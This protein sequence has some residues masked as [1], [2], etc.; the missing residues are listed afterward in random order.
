[1]VV[2][3]LL[4]RSEW[5]S[6]SNALPSQSEG[7]HRAEDTHGEVDGEKEARGDRV[8]TGRVMGILERSDRLYVATFDV[9]LCYSSWWWW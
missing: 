8:P 7:S 5:K 3:S 1:M 4:P 6:R 9:G 2:V